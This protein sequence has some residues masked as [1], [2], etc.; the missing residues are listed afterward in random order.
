MDA[1]KDY[2]NVKRTDLLLVL[3]HLETLVVSLDR[4]GSSSVDMGQSE[5]D[6]M[7]REFID[8]WSV[9]RKLSESRTV[10]SKYFSTDLGDDDM[11]ELERELQGVPYW[12]WSN[13][14]P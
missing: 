5:S 4:I 3:K 8:D 2:L 11:D 10:L 1:N 12:T 13:R 9:C 6:I 7:L 14:K